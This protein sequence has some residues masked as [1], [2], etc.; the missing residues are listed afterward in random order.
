MNYVLEIRNSKGL[1]IGTLQLWAPDLGRHEVRSRILAA[2][3][4]IVDNDL[5]APAPHPTSTACLRQD[6][7]CRQV[8]H[9][10]TCE[11]KF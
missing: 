11:P 4:D 5:G 7:C 8:G 2:I 1:I 9:D 6:W 10:G 3:S